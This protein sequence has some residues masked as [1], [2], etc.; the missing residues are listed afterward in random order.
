MRFSCVYYTKRVRGLQVFSCFY[1]IRAR[2]AQDHPRRDD[3]IREVGRWI[4]H[5]A[6]ITDVE[7]DRGEGVQRVGLEDVFHD[8][9]IP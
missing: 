6:Q 5:P 7:G 3:I 4:L 9:I 1:S 8:P 2:L